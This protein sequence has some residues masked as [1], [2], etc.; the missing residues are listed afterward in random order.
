M[1]NIQLEH[2]AKYK[3]YNAIMNVNIKAEGRERDILPFLLL[4]KENGT[5][6]EAET[7][8]KFFAKKSDHSY[9]DRWIKTMKA[10]GYIKPTRGGYKL[11]ES[12]E[13]MVEARQ[14]MMPHRGTYRIFE[15][16]DQVFKNTLIGYENPEINRNEERKNHREQRRDKKSYEKSDT[17]TLSIEKIN[18]WKRRIE[19][20][21]N[22]DETIEIID[23]E[24]KII[25]EKNNNEILIKIEY[26][27]DTAISK[28]RWEEKEKTFMN[29][30]DVKQEKILETIAETNGLEY[31]NEYGRI[32][33]GIDHLNKITKQ[34]EMDFPTCNIK[35]GQY[36]TYKVS[37][38]EN[39]PI[40]PK[41]METAL[42]WIDRAVKKEIENKYTTKLDYQDIANSKVAEILQYSEFLEEEMTQT[43]NYEEFVNEIKETKNAEKGRIY[44]HIMATIDLS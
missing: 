2:K 12:A 29:N 19:L 39:I 3:I 6:S 37:K 24:E 16:E 27:S 20:P 1:T 10:G 32:R 8:D 43:K 5:I 41:D 42:Q 17:Q 11:T 4:V 22:D 23:V 15:S 40:M 35:L 9:G 36:G 25:E 38:A 33:I 31:D 7:N 44:W 30:F 18:S 28:I 21:I 34:F 26:K 14:I 13:A